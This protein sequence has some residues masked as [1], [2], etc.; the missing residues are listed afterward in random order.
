MHTKLIQNIIQTLNDKN[1]TITE[2][3][4]TNRITIITFFVYDNIAYQILL[5]TNNNNQSDIS[6]FKIVQKNND[7]I[8]DL[9]KSNTIINEL[10]NNI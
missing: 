10:L 6:L 5:T 1:Y 9:T 4:T 3:H 2:I 7:F 8:D